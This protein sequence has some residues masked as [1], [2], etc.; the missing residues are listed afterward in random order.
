MPLSLET[1]GGHGT[2][3]ARAP[4]YL[5]NFVAEPAM[6]MVVVLLPCHFV[7]GGF[8][9]QVNSGYDAFILQ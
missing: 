4:I 3:I 2:N 7:A 9:R 5:K 6:K 1:V 8:S